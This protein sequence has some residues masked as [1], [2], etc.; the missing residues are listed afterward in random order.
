M[1][2]GIIGAMEPE[3]ALLKEQMT[4]E[5]TYEQ[6]QMPFVE[7]LLGDV[8]VVVE[9]KEVEAD[10]TGKWTYSFENLDKYEKGKLIKYSIDE[11]EVTGYTKTV[12]GYNIKNSSMSLLRSIAIYLFFC[13]FGIMIGA[14]LFSKQP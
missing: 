14:K 3:I 2:I 7:G 11:E 1:K 10:A 9:T 4:I 8:P 13:S 5:R 12:D 6:A